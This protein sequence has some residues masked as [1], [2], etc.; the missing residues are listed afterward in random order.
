[1]W[2]PQARN[3]S[4]RRPTLRVTSV[5]N[6]V[7]HCWDFF[8]H[9]SSME[10]VMLLL[11]GRLCLPWPCLV[12]FLRSVKIHLV[13]RVLRWLPCGFSVE[14]QGA[15]RMLTTEMTLLRLG[16]KVV[17][18]NPVIV[19]FCGCS[20]KTATVDRHGNKFRRVLVLEVRGQ[21]GCWCPLNCSPP[22]LVTTRTSSENEECASGVKN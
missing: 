21:A 20:A 22:Q 9:A 8:P 4:V 1:M 16:C 5:F 3:S 17:S 6:V 13:D 15:C 11:G 14:L 2:R 18:H 12:G 10:C 7:G 19:F